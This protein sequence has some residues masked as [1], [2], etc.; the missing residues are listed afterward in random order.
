ML[1]DNPEKTEFGIIFLAGHGMILDGNQT[2]L[3]NEYCSRSEFYELYKIEAH[4]RTL[5]RN[6]KNSYLVVIAACCRQIFNHQNHCKCVGAQSEVEAK[7]LLEKRKEE[8]ENNQKTLSQKKNSPQAAPKPANG[9]GGDQEEVKQ[10]ESKLETL[11]SANKVKV[12]NFIFIGVAPGVLVDA[13]TKI[14]KDTMRTF[15]EQYDKE[16]LIVEFPRILYN[17][18]GSDSQIEI[19]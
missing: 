5:T 19:T 7:R 1:K 6:F 16:T 14:I 11:G 17:L 12:Q 15:I 4:V 3:L 18:Q 13:D 10:E 8:E 9:R 2:I